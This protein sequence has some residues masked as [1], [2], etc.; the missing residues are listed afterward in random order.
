[1]YM[2]DTSWQDL[3]LLIG[4]IIYCIALIPSIFGPNKPSKWT[5]LMNAVTLTA[6]TVTYVSL[7]FMYASIAVAISALGWWV[8]F[9]QKIR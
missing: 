3:V 5:S 6:F 1:M 4:N 2:F 9:A 8:L 7:S